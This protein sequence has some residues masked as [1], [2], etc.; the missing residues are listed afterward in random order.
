MIVN[1]VSEAKTQ[2]SALIERALAGEEI[3]IN[4]AGKPVAILRKFEVHKTS[5]QPGAL[6]K[7][8][9]IAADFDILPPEIAAAFGME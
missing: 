9:S 6:K 1:T 4:R 7:K 8:I 2:L 5:R 3:I